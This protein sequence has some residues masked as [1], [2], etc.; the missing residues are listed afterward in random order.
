MKKLIFLF[1]TTCKK[2][3]FIKKKLLIFNNFTLVGFKIKICK[4]I[5]IKIEKCLLYHFIVNI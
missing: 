3:E 1:N 4:D 5:V 2:N